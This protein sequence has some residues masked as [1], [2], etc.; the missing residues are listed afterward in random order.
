VLKYTNLKEF[1]E[2]VLSAFEKDKQYER[3]KKAAKEYTQK[4][5]SEKIAGELIELFK[6][7]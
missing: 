3:C 5:S 7:L 1:R 4:N 2:C 6:K